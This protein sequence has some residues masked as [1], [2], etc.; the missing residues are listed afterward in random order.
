M[1]NFHKKII[2]I[3]FYLLIILLYIYIYLDTIV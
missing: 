2:K 3:E 1:N